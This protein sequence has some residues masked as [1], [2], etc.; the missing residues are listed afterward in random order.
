MTLSAEELLAG[1]G[2]AH[3]V[4]VPPGLMQA[5][6]EDTAARVV[7]RPLTVR[8]LQR[9]GKAA[10]DDDSLTSALMIQQ[11]LVEP[12]LSLEQVARLPAGLARFFVERI[13]AI[14]GVDTPAD[15]LA[16]LVQAPL[17]RACYV[18]AHEFGWTPEEVSGMTVGQILLFIQM[19]QSRSDA[20]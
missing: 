17:A 18:L 8:D 19:A 5:T 16:E 1:S 2:L 11:A 13:N 15:A 6:R 20:V 10:R 14:S 3:T 4:E 12:V 9:I 7:L